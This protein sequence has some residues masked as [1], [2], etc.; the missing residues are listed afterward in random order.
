MGDEKKPDASESQDDGSSSKNANG[1][2]GKSGDDVITPAVQQLIETHFQKVVQPWM[3]RINGELGG[4]RR[5]AKNQQPDK[6]SDAEG[7]TPNN[8]TAKGLKAITAEDLDAAMR[9][10]EFR[11][12]IPEDKREALAEMAEGLSY[13]E[14]LRLYQ[15]AALFALSDSEPEKDKAKSKNRGGMPANGGS[16]TQ[17]AGDRQ[18]VNRPRTQREYRA[19]KPEER[20][21]LEIEAPDFDPTDL[22]LR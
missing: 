16:R 18:G 9:L 15:T 4:F 14:R 17:A 1:A 11:A 12:K 2:G 22:P 8:G 20:K 3:Q 10:G 7:G 13:A 19:L 6:S 5:S 21:Q